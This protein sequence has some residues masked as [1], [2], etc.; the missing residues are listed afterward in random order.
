MIVSP[1][2][3]LQVL[4]G[5]CGVHPGHVLRKLPALKATILRRL[6]SLI[7]ASHT[8][9]SCSG[10]RGKT[11]RP[12]GTH[13][14]HSAAYT[15]KTPL[16]DVNECFVTRKHASWRLTAL[17]LYKRLGKSAKHHGAVGTAPVWPIAAIDDHPQQAEAVI[18]CMCTILK[19]ILQ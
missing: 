10:R 19:C 9:P 16:Q 1:V 6:C 4:S 13:S 15:R 11:Q 7:D 17:M 18:N 2:L 5:G 8:W 12:S 3:H 14:T